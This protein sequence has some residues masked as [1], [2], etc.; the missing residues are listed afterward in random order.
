MCKCYK[1]CICAVVGVIIEYNKNYFKIPNIFSLNVCTFLSSSLTDRTIN[2]IYIN[3]CIFHFKRVWL[4]QAAAL[5][6]FLP[7][8]CSKH[9]K[10]QRRAREVP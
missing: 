6:L 1:L 10:R 7:A 8:V 9:Y 5:P 2:F 4:R 3:K